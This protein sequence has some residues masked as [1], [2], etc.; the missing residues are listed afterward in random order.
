L[1]PLLD[2]PNVPDNISRISLSAGVGGILKQNRILSAR[3][4]CA[5]WNFTIIF[6]RQRRFSLRSAVWFVAEQWLV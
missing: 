4:R 6:G 2:G 3:R 1:I 5:R